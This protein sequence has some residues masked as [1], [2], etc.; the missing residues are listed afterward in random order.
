MRK[1]KA[2]NSRCFLR[3]YFYRT[4]LNKKFLHH[5]RQQ[6]FDE[7]SGLMWIRVRAVCSGG[8][9]MRCASS[10]FD[11]AVSEPC[12]DIHASNELEMPKMFHISCCC[13]PIDCEATEQRYAE[14]RGKIQTMRRLFIRGSPFFFLVCARVPPN[15]FH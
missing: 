9:E 11:H 1:G 7:R 3:F 6:L 2:P 13:G 5:Y 10:F 8:R 12:R 15:M 4:K 14:H